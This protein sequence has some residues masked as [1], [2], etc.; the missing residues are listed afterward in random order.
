MRKLKV[1]IFDFDETLYQGSE[2]FGDKWS[3]ACVDLID[4]FFSDLNLEQKRELFKKYEIPYN[5]DRNYLKE[6]PA[7]YCLKILLGEGYTIDDWINYWSTHIYSEDW[8]LVTNV[9]S[10]DL[11]KI[12][13]ENYKI[14]IVTA[15]LRESIEHY[16]KMLNID[17]SLFSEIYSNFVP[18]LKNGTKKDYYYDMIMKKEQA[19]SEECLVIGDSYESDILPAVMLGMHS[20]HVDNQNWDYTNITKRILELEQE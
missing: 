13:S 11:L 3:Q 17:I 18:R 9:I 14:Y 10:N 20:L 7:K 6:K 2:V 4:H 5:F 15:S 1:L 16:S 19:L 12:L 8:S